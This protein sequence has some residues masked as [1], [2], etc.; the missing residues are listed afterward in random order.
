MR[1]TPTG[2]RGASAEGTNE[3]RSADAGRDLPEGDAGCD[4]PKGG[5]QGVTCRS[6]DEVEAD[7]AGRASVPGGRFRAFYMDGR[8]R[9]RT[10]SVH[11]CGTPH[12]AARNPYPHGGYFPLCFQGFPRFPINRKICWAAPTGIQRLRCKECTFATVFGHV[13]FLGP[14]CS[15]FWP[16]LEAGKVTNIHSGP[17]DIYIYIS[18]KYN[19]CNDFCVRFW[20]TFTLCWLH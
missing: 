17:H 11:Q 15:F 12:H 14:K 1:C 19:T 13:V 5:A 6:L 2:G 3:M 9:G 7:G 18:G 4:L 20:Y 10:I 16:V 8:G